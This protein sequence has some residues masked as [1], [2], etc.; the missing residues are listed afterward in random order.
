V[1]RYEYE[2]AH[3]LNELKRAVHRMLR[4]LEWERRFGF[5]TIAP[6]SYY[7]QRWN[8]ARQLV[9]KW[10]AEVEKLIA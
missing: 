8:W 3:Q 7:D 6:G 9:N 4:A 2:K 5:G 10:R 1:S